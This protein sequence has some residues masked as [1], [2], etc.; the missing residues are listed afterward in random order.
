MMESTDIETAMVDSH[1]QNLQMNEATQTTITAGVDTGT[2]QHPQRVVYYPIWFSPSSSIEHDDSS[3]AFCWFC[4]FFWIFM[5]I[6]FLPIMHY[7]YY[8]F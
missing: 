1:A 4:F 6:V 3:C 5:L 8:Y 2:I 7:R